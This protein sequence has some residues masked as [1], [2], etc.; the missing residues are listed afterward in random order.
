MLERVKDNALSLSINKATGLSFSS[1]S[2]NIV[3]A[4]LSN[5]ITTQ[6]GIVTSNYNSE[7][8][9]YLT[10]FNTRRVELNQ[11]VQRE[12]AIDPL[13][14]GS[15]SQGV[16]LAKA[17]E[18]A[19]IAMGGRGSGNWTDQD[20][21]AIRNGEWVDG[22]EGH[23]INNVADHPTL[24][25]DPDNIMYYRTREDHVKYGHNGDVNNESHGDLIDKNQ[26]LKNTNKQRVIKNELRG[27][28]L[29]AAIGMGVGFSLS[30]IAKLAERGINPETFGDSLFE[31]IG[32]GLESGVFSSASYVVGRAIQTGLVKAG[33]D[34]STKV[35]S[36]ISFASVGLAI[37][38]FAS[39]IQYIK[40]RRSGMDDS[41]AL[42]E[43][44]KQ[45][46]FSV[47]VMAVSVMAQGIYGGYAG[48]IVST[49]VGLMYF[50]YNI[51]KTIKQRQIGEKIRVYAIEQYRDIVANY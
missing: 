2:K 4:G 18:K 44:G 35:G 21:Q 36:A 25:Q 29:S 38:L 3:L 26:M 39:I 9:N 1:T 43:T 11:T 31:S 13:Y 27:L 48:L 34:L 30:F 24:Q 20:I 50:G 46:L 15:R 12:L 17:Y 41:T 7:L 6:I 14:K 28:K 8:T 49:A 32:A 23:H 40:L 51:G 22:A 47:S 5:S 33:L 37:T 19:D 42:I 45:A 10:S 16:K